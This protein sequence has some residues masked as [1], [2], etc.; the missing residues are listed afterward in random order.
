MSASD[1]KTES[2]IGDIVT[3]DSPDMFAAPGSGPYKRVRLSDQST[4]QSEGVSDWSNEFDSALPTS[5][6][7]R[8]SDWGNQIDSDQVSSQSEH[9]HAWKIKSA[10]EST[11][12]A[13]S[14]WDTLSYSSVHSCTVCPRVFGSR[15]ALLDHTRT[16]TGERP[17]K[18]VVCGNSFNRQFNLTVHLRTH[19]GEK[20]Y[21]C[22]QCGKTFRHQQHYK[23][24][25]QKAHNMFVI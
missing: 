15:S 16:R 14:D 17:Y 13:K 3:A 1:V 5:Q 22:D 25:M 24:H 9:E 6:G 19:T 8:E 2:D 20:P 12:G 10:H 23:L 7:E 18:C 21:E 4:S 11:T